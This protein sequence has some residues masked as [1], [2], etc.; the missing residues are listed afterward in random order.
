[1]IKSISD[2]L[3]AGK[4]TLF[5]AW[6][7]L[8]PR[9]TDARACASLLDWR[10]ADLE[11]S[12]GQ[13][14]DRLRASSRKRQEMTLCGR[15]CWH[16]LGMPLIRYDQGDRG[17]L[18]TF[19]CP[20]KRSFRILEKIEG[21]K[22]DA[23]TLSTGEIISSGFL[24]DLTYGVLLDYPDAISS[25]CLLQNEPDVW[26]LEV[27]PGGQW[28]S[29]LAEKIAGSLNRKLARGNVSISCKIVS[30]VRKTSSGK[31]N[32]IISFIQR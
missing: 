20:C 19:R 6:C 1:V 9:R 11:R 2:L 23:F 30:E 3:S 15:R 24:L 32:P 27:V 13:P 14:F 21:R 29:G 28:S 25:F 4:N 31:T 17:S 7:D 16:N 18:R 5:G 26:T 10:V 8:L 12:G 22:N